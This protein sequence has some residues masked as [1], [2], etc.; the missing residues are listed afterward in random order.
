MA[1]IEFYTMMM[2]SVIF[3]PFGVTERL[4][5]LSNSAISLMFNSGAKM[6]VICFLQVMIAKILGAYLTN[7]KASP[8]ANLSSLVQMSVMCIF[9]AYITKK[10]PDLV[11]SFLNGSPA[12][13]GGGMIQQAKASVQQVGTVMGTGLGAV[14]GASAAASGLATRGGGAA[15][16]MSQLGIPG[17][18]KIGHALDTGAYL[19]KAGAQNALANNSFTR[20]VARGMK[21]VIG[22]NGDLQNQSFEKGLRRLAG[23]ETDAKDKPTPT[24]PIEDVAEHGWPK[25][26]GNGGSG[27]GTGVKQGTSGGNEPDTKGKDGTRV[28]SLKD[29]Q[30]LT[31]EQRQQAISSMSNKSLQKLAQNVDS[32][33]QQSLTQEQRQQLKNFKSQKDVDSMTKEQRQTLNSIFEE[34]GKP[35]KK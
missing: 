16:K 1:R 31:Q 7:L 10:I 24:R 28:S 19:L 8:F 18:G 27:G 5:F 17:G 33:D 13:S 30:N 14:A 32:E 23:L 15:T 22:D 35:P 9:F 2:L 21:G 20:G 25:D 11:S 12:L 34:I 29:L 3:L 6:M 26:G 4:A